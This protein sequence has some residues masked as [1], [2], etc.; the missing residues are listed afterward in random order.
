MSAP[1]LL[2]TTLLAVML[3]G[4]TQQASARY[5]SSDP[6]GLAGG[7]NTYTYVGGNPLSYVDPLGLEKLN[8]I[9]PREP[10]LWLSGELYPNPENALVIISHGRPDA[11]RNMNA[12]QL[13]EFIKGNSNWKQGQPVIL[14]ACRTGQGEDSVAENLSKIL[15]TPVIAPD[16]PVWNVFLWDLGPAAPQLS[17]PNRADWSKPGNWRCFGC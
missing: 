2:E 15:G 17:N 9:S 4:F 16:Q 12:A 1:R 3:V 5:T 11:V 14:N 7:I 13:A 10:I 6:I 8:L